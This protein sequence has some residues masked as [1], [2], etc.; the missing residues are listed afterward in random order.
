MNFQICFLRSYVFLNIVLKSS[1]NLHK[2]MFINL[3]NAPMTFFNEN[4]PGRILNR[5]SKDIGGIDELVPRT[6]SE[7]ISVY[8][9]CYKIYIIDLVIIKRKNYNI[10]QIILDSTYYNWNYSI[11]CNSESCNDNNINCFHSIIC[12]CF[13]I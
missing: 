12:M 5:F 11:S 6:M 3:I 9:K 8:E 2:A 1:T 13:K 10:N 4:P 7:T